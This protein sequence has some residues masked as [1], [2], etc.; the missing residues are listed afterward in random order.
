MCIRDRDIT[1]RKRAEELLQA[2]TERL[3]LALQA[4]LM[5]TWEWNIMDNHVVWSTETQNIFG[6]GVDGFG[7]TY[8][9]YLGFVAP[10]TREAVDDRVKQFLNS[11]RV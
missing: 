10:E 5:G 7:E 6:V 9:A 3:Q 4:A 8:Q 2:S 11:A 1:D